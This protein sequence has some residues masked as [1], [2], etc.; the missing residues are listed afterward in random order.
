MYNGTIHA[1]S[2]RASFSQPPV[3]LPGVPSGFY[4]GFGLPSFE[5]LYIS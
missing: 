4:M 2:L 3:R 1:I 5:G